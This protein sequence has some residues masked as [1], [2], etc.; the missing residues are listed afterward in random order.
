MSLSDYD[1]S[2]EERAR[3]AAV[4]FGPWP[5]CEMKQTCRDSACCL[6]SCLV[7][8]PYTPTGRLNTSELRI[9][10]HCGRDPWDDWKPGRDLA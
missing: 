9:A 7:S 6:G 1:Y 8:R 2:P 5:Q 4:K 3:M 10:A